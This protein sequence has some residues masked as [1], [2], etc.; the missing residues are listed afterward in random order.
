MSIQYQD[1]DSITLV[2]LTLDWKFNRLCQNGLSFISHYLLT[3]VLLRLSGFY[4][5]LR[6][7]TLTT[8]RLQPR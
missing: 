2:Q 6:I 1:L 7:V 3:F 4:L 5:T 8:I